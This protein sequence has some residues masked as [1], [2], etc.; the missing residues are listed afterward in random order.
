M[1]RKAQYGDIPAI[2]RLLEQVN[3]V[4][5]LG[6]PDIFRRGTKYNDAELKEII[7]N[8]SR[9]LLVAEDGEGNVCGHAFCEFQQ[10][11]GSRLL[12]D[13]KTLYVDD[14]CVDENHR[15]QNFGTELYEAVRGAAVDT[16][17]HNITLNVWEM[18]PAAMAFY[19]SLGLEP[20]KTTLEERL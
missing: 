4:H 7:C 9:L 11:L 17:C 15:R 3:L 16:G 19:R 10:H 1:V 13:I 5:H 18:N 20:L 12:T 2:L 8:P 6:R 14:I